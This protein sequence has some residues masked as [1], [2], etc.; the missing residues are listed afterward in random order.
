MKCI[1]L[2]IFTFLIKKYIIFLQAHQNV[3]FHIF[4]ST[5][6]IYELPRLTLPYSKAFD[7]EFWTP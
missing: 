1:A 6:K 3:K 4:V 5:A 7:Q 2:M